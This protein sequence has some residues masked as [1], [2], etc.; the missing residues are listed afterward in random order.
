[1]PDAPENQASYPQLAVQQPGIGF[2][3]IAGS[4]P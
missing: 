4:R 2:R 3:I 1:M